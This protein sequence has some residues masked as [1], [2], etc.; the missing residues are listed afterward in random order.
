MKLSGSCSCGEGGNLCHVAGNV[1][2]TLFPQKHYSHKPGPT[3]GAH[4]R[5]AIVILSRRASSRWLA[6]RDKTSMRLMR[7]SRRLRCSSKRS[8]SDVYRA[9]HRDICMA[10]SRIIGL[11]TMLDSENERTKKE[12]YKSKEG[13]GETTGGCANHN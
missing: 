5:A 3:Q 11:H 12:K 6:R 1:E 13:E 4:S 7:L 8:L 10:R 2:Q 9:T